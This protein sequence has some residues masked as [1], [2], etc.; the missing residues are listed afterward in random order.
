MESK[1]RRGSDSFHTTT[2]KTKQPEIK[3]PLNLSSIINEN[4]F[5]EETIENIKSAYQS[6][7]PFQHIEIPDF[8][9]QELLSEI[10]KEIKNC[11]WVKKKNDLYSFQQTGDLASFSEVRDYLIS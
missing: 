6:A 7:E 9:S 4:L 1:K 10:Q 3:N 5:S 2:K 11:S 8:L